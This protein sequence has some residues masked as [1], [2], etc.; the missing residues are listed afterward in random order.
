MEHREAFNAIK[1]EIAQ[2]LILAY[3]DPNKETILQTNANIKG[4]GVCLLQQGKPVYFASKA[5]TESQKGYVVIELES[6]GSSMGYGKI[7]SFP[8]WQPLYIIN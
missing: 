8:I 4:L 1:K 6:L 7:P 5:L 2:A 3:Y